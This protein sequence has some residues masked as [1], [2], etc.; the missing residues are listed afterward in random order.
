ME[1]IIEFHDVEQ[2]GR[3]VSL[4]NRQPFAVQILHDASL[5]DAKSIL[6]LCFLGLHTPLCVRIAANETQSEDFRTAIGPYLS[7]RK[8]AQ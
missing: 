8:Q 4:A 1:F 5:L 6:N 7:S 3:F 2:I